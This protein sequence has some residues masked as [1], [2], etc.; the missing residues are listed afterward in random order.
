MSSPKK[1]KK[2][3]RV[4]TTFEKNALICLMCRNVHITG[5][6]DAEEIVAFGRRKRPSAGGKT[7]RTR[8]ALVS[9]SQAL[10]TVATELNKAVNKGAYAEDIRVKDVRKMIEKV[11]AFD[12]VSFMQL[13][14]MGDSIMIIVC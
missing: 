3:E 7:K 9:E 1:V 13:P 14:C 10:M 8:N 6:P 11:R 5:T 4:W 12:L 2:V